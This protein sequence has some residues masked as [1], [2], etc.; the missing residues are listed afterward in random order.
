VEWTWEEVLSPL[1]ALWKFLGLRCFR[2]ATLL[3]PL[4]RP[5]EEESKTLLTIF[6]LGLSSNGNNVYSK[7]TEEIVRVGH[8]DKENTHLKLEHPHEREA[9]F[10]SH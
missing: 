4:P 10:Y 8:T 6:L 1:T 2:P 9:Y 7:G 5:K 3:R